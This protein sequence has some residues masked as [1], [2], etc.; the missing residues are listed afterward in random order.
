MAQAIPERRAMRRFDMRLPAAVRMPSN[1][2][3]EIA[4][5]T[6]NVS[7]RGVFFHLPQAL[8]LGDRLA[9]TLTFPPHVTL[10]EKVR[11]RFDARVI[12]VEPQRAF[13]GPV[14]IAAAI[15]AYEFLRNYPMEELEESTAPEQNAQ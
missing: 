10:T 1:D 4:T 6:D 8:Q 3:P 15:E 13:G 12:R 7:A 2:G 14:G 5:E 9:V 11:V